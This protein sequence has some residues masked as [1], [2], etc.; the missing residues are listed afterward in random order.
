[1]FR[2]VAYAH[3]GVHRFAVDRREMLLGSAESCAIHLPF[4]GVSSQHARLV[5]DGE[6]LTL[7][8]L[9]A[10]KG[11]LV[12]GERVKSASLEVLD[13]IRLGSIA[14]LVEDVVQE[15]ATEIPSDASPV[16]LPTID[17]AT[18]LQHLI[19]VSDWVLADS[20]SNTTLES[21]VIELIKDFGGGVLYLFQ[22]EDER[23]AIKFVVSSEGKW[24]TS[25]EALLAQVDTARESLGR[26]SRRPTFGRAA[27]QPSA[28]RSGGE[29]AGRLDSGD[30]WLAFQ[31]LEALDRPYLFVA[32]FP[33]YR[34][35]DWSPI[36]GLGILGNLLILGLVHH[37]GHFEPILL[38]LPSSAELTLAPGLVVGQ[39]AA[40]RRVLDELRAAIDSPVHVL[41]RGEPGVLK[42][43]LARSLHLSGARAAGPFEVVCC[44]GAKPMQ[45]E[46]ELFG[47]RV[48]GRVE[49]VIRQGKLQTADGGSLL[50]ED[51]ETLPLPL[52]DRLMR[53]LRTGQP[54]SVDGSPAAACDVRL[55]CSSRAPLEALAARDQLRIDLAY[56]LSRFAVDVPALRERREDLP[57]LIQAEINRC[58]HETGKRIHGITVKALEALAVYDYPGNLIELENIVRRLVYLCPSGRPI[59]EA[60]LPQ[61]IRLAKIAGLK[62]DISSELDL[63]RL[64]ADC[65]RAAIREA[66]RRSDGNKAA[67]ARALG[68]SR[69]GLA[70]KMNR[71][72]LGRGKVQRGAVS[73]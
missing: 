55:I 36:D 47:G 11:L 5:V 32:A 2:L 54:E 18:M 28:P 62:P 35:Q 71:L 19:R 6:T 48:E 70:M 16:T 73:S 33:N 46:A 61:E 68:L 10:R 63:E 41:L 39:S 44:A 51:V 49:A 12:N 7:H 59:D 30:A 14:L 56:S 67:A 27:A 8:D 38:G 26:T 42:E 66:L 15:V 17:A 50:L 58:C 52:Q 45:V 23:R 3:N 31:S 64:V 25:G 37:I 65:E 53:F 13:E 29:F 21:L 60:M 1:M 43:L 20:A 57:M 34:Q 24:L 69:N 22:G 40:M 9:G 72:G 4:P